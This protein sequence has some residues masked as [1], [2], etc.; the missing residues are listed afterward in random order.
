MFYASVC[1]LQNV[2]VVTIRQRSWKIL[3]Q[4]KLDWSIR[5]AFVSLIFSFLLWNVWLLRIAWK[6][7][8]WQFR[9]YCIATY[10]LLRNQSHRAKKCCERERERASS[11]LSL[12]FLK[13]GRATLVK[14]LE[15][16]QAT[17]MYK[18]SSLKQSILE[19]SHLETPV[20]GFKAT[21]AS[22]E[23]GLTLFSFISPVCLLHGLFRA[24]ENEV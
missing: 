14:E 1:L 21:G 7:L 23:S 18:Q 8:C 20:L 3:L 2:F 16:P 12:L 5:I 10:G 4:S 13:A 22:E 6:T 24:V 9:T 11:F 15:N 19:E 17:F